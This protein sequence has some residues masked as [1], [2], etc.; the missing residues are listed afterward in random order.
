MYE[1]HMAQGLRRCTMQTN[2]KLRIAF[3]AMSLSALCACQ[4]HSQP[5]TSDERVVSATLKLL[6]SDG[7]P[8]CVDN[9]TSGQPLGVFRTT[10]RNRPAG[11]EPPSWFAPA[12]LRPPA[13]LSSFELLRGAQVDSN[14]HI[15]QPANSSSAMAAPLQDALNRSAW[16]LSTENASKE[17]SNINAWGIKG[18]ALHSWIIN[19]LSPRCEPNYRLSNPVS[20]QNVS[21]ITVIADHWATIYAFNRRGIDWVP[22]AQWSN[23]IY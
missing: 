14:V 1:P 21:F 10:I 20:N 5:Q 7:K 13:A 12:A 19:R 8:V 16:Q 11:L 4:G 15:T 2:M 3:A 9:A 18:V 22:I 23:W 6:A 17:V